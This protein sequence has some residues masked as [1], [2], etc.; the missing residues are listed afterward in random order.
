M[1]I[2]PS[3]KNTKAFE[4]I[5]GIKRLRA[6]QTSGTYKFKPLPED[7]RIP[8][9]GLKAKRVIPHRVKYISGEEPH[10]YTQSGWGR[11]PLAVN[12][13]F[14]IPSYRLPEF[15]YP[16]ILTLF[17]P[18]ERDL[19]INVYLGNMY[20]QKRLAS[21][22]VSRSL[23]LMVSNPT[24]VLTNFNEPDA[25][26]HEYPVIVAPEDFLLALA[27]FGKAFQKQS[28]GMEM[29][30]RAQLN[31]HDISE[32]GKSARTEFCHWDSKLFGFEI[33]L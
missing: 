18:G 26:K 31:F 4:G 2:F 5:F 11:I 27:L 6:S 23:G 19:Q 8:P 17:R 24:R 15:F 28:S 25:L 32:D 1:F 33:K 14:G 10:Q 9:G 22:L 7:K 16:S 20:N 30:T 3:I 12:R 29:T 13:Y 21:R